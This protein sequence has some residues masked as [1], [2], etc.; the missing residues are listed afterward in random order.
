MPKSN[1]KLIVESKKQEAIQTAFNMAG[2]YFKN[3]SVITPSSDSDRR[4]FVIEHHGSDIKNEIIFES[5]EQQAFLDWC[6]IENVK[7]EKEVF[8][9]K[10][11]N[12]SC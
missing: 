9:V 11:I 12:L 5:N 4:F 2:T 10:L 7:A 6:A 1:Y 3:V 8:N